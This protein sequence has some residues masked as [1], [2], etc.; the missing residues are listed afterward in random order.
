MKYTKASLTA[1]AALL[2]KEQTKRDE[3]LSQ[4]TYFKLGGPA[5]LFFIAKSAQ[6]LE[7]AVK[8]ADQYGVPWF[9]LGGGSNIL[10]GDL[11]VRGLVIKNETKKLVVV[12]NLLTAESGVPMASLV[13][14][15]IDNGLSGLESFMSLPGTV[16]GAIY[17]NSHYRP[18]EQELIGNVVESA[19]LYM[20]EKTETVQQDW[21]HFKYDYSRLQEEKALVLEVTFR[22]HPGEKQEMRTRALEMVK[23]RNERQPIGLACSGCIFQNPIGI[24]SSKLIDMAGLKGARVGGAYVS[25]K[26]ANFIINDGSATTRD[27]LELIVNV[28]KTVKEKLGTDIHSE[29]FPVGEFSWFPDELKR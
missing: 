10:V 17:N 26:H 15:A 9:V 21:F 13:S 3:L 19:R 25:D 12:D 28:K 22:L 24:S 7:Q 18:E 23:R 1:L 14:F 11:G 20:R 4:H 16:G 27:V 6:E 2:P 8:A 5:D 29:I